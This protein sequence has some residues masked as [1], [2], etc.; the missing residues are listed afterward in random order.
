ML[1]TNITPKQQSKSIEDYISD[2]PTYLLSDY[3]IRKQSYVD[4]M[5]YVSNIK[6]ED[7]KAPIK[8]KL[9]TKPTLDKDWGEINNIVFGIHN[10][11]QFIN[12]ISTYKKIKVGTGYIYIEST[13]YLC[14]LIKHPGKYP[15]VVIRIPVE[16]PFTYIND[17][18]IGVLFSFPI[19]LL[20]T[21][22]SGSKSKNKQYK[23]YLT[24]EVSNTY[25]LNMEM[26]VNNDIKT[27]IIN[28]IK[29]IDNDIIN[30]I[31]LK[32]NMLKFLNNFSLAKTNDIS[33]TLAN[34]NIILLK[35]L[36]INST[37]LTLDVLQNKQTGCFEFKDDTLYY[38]IRSA[39]KCDI[40]KVITKSESDYWPQIDYNGSSYTIHDYDQMFKLSHYSN[41]TSKDGIFYIFSTFLNTFAFTILITDQNVMINENTKTYTFQDIFNKGTQVFE[42]Y[43]LIEDKE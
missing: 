39:N 28:D 27:T 30:N 25:S 31:V 9:T 29:K 12:M 26:V 42:L 41:K 19:E 10:N 18:Y 40:K 2:Y 5:L 3:Q 16:Y 23:L 4:N 22:E 20:Y 21:K 33:Y 32:P 15:L 17:K 36:P 11:E 8:A 37:V 38:V 43:L 13:Q 35:K 14:I 1:F 6:G 24:K 34:M 7:N